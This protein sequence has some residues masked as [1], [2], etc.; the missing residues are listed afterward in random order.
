MDPQAFVS[1]QTPIRLSRSASRLTFPS[2]VW[3]NSLVQHICLRSLATLSPQAQFFRESGYGHHGLVAVLFPGELVT[4]WLTMSHSVLDVMT[5]WWVTPHCCFMIG[6][7]APILSGTFLSVYKQLFHRIPS[8]SIYNIKELGG[9]WV[10]W[11]KLIGRVSAHRALSL[12]V[13]GA[14]QALWLANKQRSHWLGVWIGVWI[15]VW[16]PLRDLLL[17]YARTFTSTHAICDNFCF[18]SCNLL[19]CYFSR[20]K[21]LIN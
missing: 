2:W 16:N 19:P 18:R 6:P 13:I 1:I 9:L 15:G 12:A 17:L 10:L 3:N 21:S 8:C 5:H 11:R 4:G 14:E 20:L 7:R